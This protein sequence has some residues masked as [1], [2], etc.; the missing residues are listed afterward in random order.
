MNADTKP[1]KKRP[2]RAK[3]ALETTPVPTVAPEPAEA[4]TATFVP[5]AEAPAK[6]KPKAKTPAKPVAATAPVKAP[7]AAPGSYQMDPG[8]DAIFNRYPNLGTEPVYCQIELLDYYA[9]RMD[10]RAAQ[11]AGR[12]LDVLHAMLAGRPRYWDTFRPVAV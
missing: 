1:P 9:Q 7:P 10:K 8:A 5:K 2:S 12:T 11:R 3:K 6:P 4:A